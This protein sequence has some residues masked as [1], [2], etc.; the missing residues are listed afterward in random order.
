V[1]EIHI[2]LNFRD[3]TAGR[4]AQVRTQH[5]VVAEIGELAALAD[6]LAAD[7]AKEGVDY[8]DLGRWQ[9][10]P[11]FTFRVELTHQ[12]G[13]LAAGRGTAADAT[14]LGEKRRALADS[15]PHTLPT[16]A[17]PDAERPAA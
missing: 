15:M 11:P 4:S 13:R 16:S 3:W 14:E 9:G 17:H 12:G 10:D 2:E 8:A 7:A 5:E 6:G 1:P